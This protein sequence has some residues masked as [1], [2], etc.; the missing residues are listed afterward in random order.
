MG[1]QNKATG[2]PLRSS[3]LLH[4]DA[5]NVLSEDEL[6]Q[7]GNDAA[8]STSSYSNSSAD[9]YLTSTMTS[10]YDLSPWNSAAASPFAE[11]PWTTHHLR[12]IPTSIGFV[13]SLV[14][15]E[16]HVYSLAAAGDL[17]YTG[18]ESRNIRVWKGREELSS[19]RSS[20]GLVKAIVV[21]GD[22]VF[23][24]HR[25][26][27]IRVWR[28]SSKDPSF[29]KRVGTLPTRAEFLR[30]SVNP[31][32]YVEGRRRRRSALWL[33][34]FDAVSCLSLDE[35]AGL[36]YSGSWDKTVKV[37][38]I[39]DF[40][41]LESLNAHD[42][43]VNAVATAGFDGLVFTGSADGTVKAWRREVAAQSKGGGG[44]TRHVTVQTLIRQEGA[45]TALVVVAAAG[46]VYCSSS[47]G[48]VRYWRRERGGEPLSLGGALWG[49]GMAVLCLAAAG[50]IVVSGSADGTVRVWRRE[51]GGAHGAVAVLIGHE[52][53]IKCLAV[54]EAAEEP[55]YVVY[56]GS[57]DN[58]VKIWRLAE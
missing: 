10:P 7:P 42:D 39:S 31:S 21:A 49:H 45:V 24:G 9:G 12:H 50:S 18:S 23:T 56:S 43:A 11:S 25:D 54:E 19:F 16:G 34:H 13:A 27:K 33:R 14:R 22:R 44:A 29:H 4:S 48:V 8:A 1:A 53:P 32:N 38:R 36:L 57:L 5:I 15:R 51:K 2:T 26:G 55:R 46:A 58:S 52:A 47:E 30:S 17:L 41:C 6:L 40:K 3:K 37:W 28:A 35:G 20:S